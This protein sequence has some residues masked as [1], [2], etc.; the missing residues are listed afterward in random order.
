[1]RRLASLTLLVGTWLPTPATAQE[2]AAIVAL[3]LDTSGSISPELLEQTRAR[4][5][6]IL[7]ALPAGSEVALLTFDDAS[8]VILDRTRDPEAVREALAGVSRAGRY[9]A[10][11]DA[12]YDASRYLQEAPRARKAIVLVTDGKDENSA[13]QAEDGLRVAVE[14]KIPVYAV[15]VGRV[16][17]AVLR[18]IAKLT[19][20]EYAPMELADGAQIAASIAT[21]EATG[22]PSARP[23]AAPPASLAAT[24]P[25]PAGG[26]PVGLLVAGGVLLLVGA[27]A[28]VLALRSRGS[29]STSGNDEATWALGREPEDGAEGA[30]STVVM[31]S[32]ELG[33]VDKTVMLRVKPVLRCTAGPA[34]GKV[35]A[36]KADSALSIGRAPT[37]DIELADASVSGEHCRVRP[38]QG[39]FVL[40]DLKSTNGTFV[41]DK[42]VARQVLREGNVIRVGETK[43]TYTLE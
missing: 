18:R 19:S 40:H 31:R 14:A 20:G 10:L 8:R 21:L 30:E 4:A 26:P 25:A 35:F 6:S 2:P 1:M 32:P 39:V 37:N 42:R 41:N 29:P 7:D 16:Q 28:A 43:L 9:T 22:G 13:L 3:T 23:P 5:V 15:G 33:S 27:G 11:Y 38:E 12:L 24:R 36:L 34:D 17:E